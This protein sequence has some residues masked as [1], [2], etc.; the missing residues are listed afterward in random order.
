MGEEARI[1]FNRETTWGETP[2][3]TL[4]GKILRPAREGWRYPREEEKVCGSGGRHS[5]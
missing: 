4:I 2:S 5:L 3:K 1:A